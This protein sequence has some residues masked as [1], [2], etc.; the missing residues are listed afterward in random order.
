MPDTTLTEPIAEQVWRSK[1]RLRQT[2][3]QPNPICTPVGAGWR[4]LC[5]TLKPMIATT[6]VCALRAFLRIID[7]CLA[8]VFWLGPGAAAT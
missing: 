1:Y 5:L 4:S 7:S 8:D 3:M 6:G 2:A